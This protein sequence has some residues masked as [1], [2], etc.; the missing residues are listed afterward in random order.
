M[1]EDLEDGNVIDITMNDLKE[2]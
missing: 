2:D 1:P